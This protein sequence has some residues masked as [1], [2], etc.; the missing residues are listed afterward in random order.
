MNNFNEMEKLVDKWEPTGL[1]I[2]CKDLSDKIQL[3]DIL[4][5]MADNVM[6][7]YNEEDSNEETQTKA[8]IL[9]PMVV[10]VFNEGVRDINIDRLIEITDE[11]F[12][13]LKQMEEVAYNNID[14]EAEF[15]S[16]CA[17]TYI[18]EYKNG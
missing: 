6:H 14:A 7:I 10:R 13:K 17:D 9:I 12:P 5:E 8:G 1:L 3:S 16:M 4:E 18:K 11:L 15:T 2:G